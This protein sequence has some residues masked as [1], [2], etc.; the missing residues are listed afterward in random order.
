M[1]DLEDLYIVDP[2]DE[3]RIQQL[4]DFN[5]MKDLEVL[6]MLDPID[7]YGVQQLKELDGKK[8]LEVLYMVDP[9]NP[10]FPDRH[11]FVMDF[12]HQGIGQGA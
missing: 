2:I 9:S 5:C 12:W 8:G 3:Y 4:K 1:K 10:W 7:V 6:Y 11:D